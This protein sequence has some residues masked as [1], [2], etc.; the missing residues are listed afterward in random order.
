MFQ[1]CS[2]KGD[3]MNKPKKKSPNLNFSVEDCG[4]WNSCYDEMDAYYQ[5][6]IREQYIKKT[7]LPSVEDIEEVLQNTPLAIYRPIAIG[8]E[9]RNPKLLYLKNFKIRRRHVK[10]LAQVL[11][12][13]IKKEI[14]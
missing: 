1:T 12:K 4:I 2:K 9:K 10:R 6:L 7:D 3:K 5:Q 14:K 13:K 8:L 11:A